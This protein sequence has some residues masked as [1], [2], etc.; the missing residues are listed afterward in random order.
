MVG[1]AMPNAAGS[2]QRFVKRGLS[3]GLLGLSLA[4][5]LAACGS[6]PASSGTTTSTSPP[7]ET[8]HGYTLLTSYATAKTMLEHGKTLYVISG[9]GF[10]AIH[11]AKGL[12][13]GT[14]LFV[15]G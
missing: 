6:S 13:R 15:K 5:G 14:A 9:K 3:I 11:S 1:S 10:R 8:L 7:T 12:P 4:F 2:L